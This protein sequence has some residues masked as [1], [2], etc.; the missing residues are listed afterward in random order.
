MKLRRSWLY[1]AALSS[2]LVPL[3]GRPAL[4]RPEQVRRAAGWWARRVDALGAAGWLGAS[5]PAL[6]RRLGSCPAFSDADGRGLRCLKAHACPWCHARDHAARP[7]ALL[8]ARLR[9][10][11]GLEAWSFGWEAPCGSYAEAWSLLARH[12][13]R[14]HARSGAE[15]SAVYCV[16]R[17]DPG[18]A[19]AVCRG[20]LL[21]PAGRTPRRAPA[22]RR[23]APGLSG[24]AAAGTSVFAY[25][26]W[27]LAADPGVAAEALEKGYG[28]RRLS[29]YGGLYGAPAGRPEGDDPRG[30]EDEEEAVP[31][32]AG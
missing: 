29:L 12:R 18:G 7:L 14:P 10:L 23:L 5:T 32:A 25:P 19:L 8:S 28:R 4:P 17:P 1:D 13:A 20:V 26:A 9:A 2:V 16:A 15:S 11:P 6:R 24:L 27:V 22:A 31:A 3:Y 30:D 21:L